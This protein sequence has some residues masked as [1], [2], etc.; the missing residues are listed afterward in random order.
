MIVKY[1]FYMAVN[2]KFIFFIIGDDHS[3]NSEGSASTSG[4]SS[5]VSHKDRINC[6][7]S[8]M[9]SESD[10][11]GRRDAVSQKGKIPGKH[12]ISYE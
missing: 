11:K 3:E 2:L 8:I 7:S 6:M 9:L 1:F 12:L 10:I 5:L 4:C